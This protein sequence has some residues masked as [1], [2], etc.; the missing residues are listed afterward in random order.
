MLFNIDVS[1]NQPLKLFVLRPTL[2]QGGAD[3][4]TLTL[5]KE[6]DRRQFAPSLVLMRNEGE[7]LVDIPT[8]VE[9][10]FLDARSSWTA[11]LSLARL[12]RKHKPHILFSTSSGF[13]LVAVI[14]F[15]LAAQHGRLVLSERNVLFHGKITLKRRIA[16]FLKRLLYQR[17]H[18]ITAV[19]QGVKDDLVARMHLQPE[20]VSVVYNPIVTKDIQK[21]AAQE[22]DHVWFTGDIPV[23]LGVGRLVPEKN[24][25]MLI[26]AFAKVRQ[27]R[28]VHLVIL[29]EGALRQDL[30]M[31]VQRLGVENDVWFAGFDKNPFKYMSKCALFVLSSNFE[32]LPGVLIQAMACGSA[33][34]STDCPSG[35]SE[36][37]EQGTTGFLIPVGDEN[38]L[39]KK[40]T[41]LLDN[42]VIRLQIGEA[43]R[44]SAERFRVNKIIERYVAAI[45][46]KGLI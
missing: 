13:N 15:T 39:A 33:V 20:T 12:L 32:G 36:I 7:Y 22:V 25:E 43:A 37:I 19:S 40:I 17:A 29:G 46:G 23:I 28:E 11:W 38:E 3:R 24:F 41:F 9:A 26:R 42:P 1:S 34:I 16:V 44:Q 45:T 35:P 4:V 2:G 14:A 27:T 18:S 8:D 30:S 5:L 10:Y 21:L 6:L 31:L